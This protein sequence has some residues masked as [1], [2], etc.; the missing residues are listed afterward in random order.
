LVSS[1]WRLTREFWAA[2]DWA[3]EQ[4]QLCDF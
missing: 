1:A 3:M 2:G 4:L